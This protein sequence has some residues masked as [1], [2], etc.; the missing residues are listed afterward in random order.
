MEKSVN[1]YKQ[2]GPDD[3]DWE[4]KFE[5]RADEQSIYRSFRE[6]DAKL[7][8]KPVTKKFNIHKESKENKKII[9]DM[10]KRFT[11]KT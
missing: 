1:K 8:P 7:I 2:V 3:E 5:Y 4:D 10:I 11:D 9:Q 6:F